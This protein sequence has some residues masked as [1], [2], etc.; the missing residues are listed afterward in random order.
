MKSV[1]FYE[2]QA[3]G[4]DQV[5]AV[6]PRHAAYTE[7]FIARGELIAVGTFA[8]PIKDGSMAVF[9]DRASAEAFIAGDPFVLEKLV[10]PTIKDWN[11]KL[12]K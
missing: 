8:D 9:R 11:E 1:V 5:M 3:T 12:L 6:F 10:K 2:T 7:A 4:M